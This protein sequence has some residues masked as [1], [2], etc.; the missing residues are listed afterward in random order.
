MRIVVNGVFTWR[1]VFDADGILGITAGQV[2]TKPPF[3]TKNFRAWLNII[4]ATRQ[5]TDTSAGFD[6][7]FFSLNIDNARS[8]QAILSWQCA[9]HKIDIGNKA[10]I[11]RLTEA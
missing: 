1:R 2:V 11:N 9:R 3:T 8:P 10:R 7:S 6:I 4:V 5:N